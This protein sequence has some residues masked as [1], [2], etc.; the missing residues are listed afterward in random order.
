MNEDL[1]LQI[2]NLLTTL[3]ILPALL[4]WL[5]MREREEKLHY[6]D[7]YHRTLEKLADT[8]L[9]TIQLWQDMQTRLIDDHRDEREARVVSSSETSHSA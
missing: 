5:F 6:L 4:F 2:W 3:G 1:I 9:Q 8:R 7:L